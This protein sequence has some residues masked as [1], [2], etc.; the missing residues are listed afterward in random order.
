MMGDQQRTCLPPCPLEISCSQ[1]EP[2]TVMPCAAPWP[3]AVHGPISAPCPTACKP[4]HSATGSIASA[5]LS[6]VTSTNSNTSGQSQPDTT[7]E[8]TISWH[9]SNSLQSVSGCEV[10][11]RSPRP[12]VFAWTL[13]EDNILRDCHPNLKRA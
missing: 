2:T 6:N 1:T 4:S 11:S 12:K 3:S 10:M 5:T 13:R 7:S 8:T 9:Q